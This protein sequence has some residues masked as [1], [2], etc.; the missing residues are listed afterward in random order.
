M[1]P[2]MD[3]VFWDMVLKM[4]IGIV[5]FGGIVAVAD[6]IERRHWKGLMI[7]GR[8]RDPMDSD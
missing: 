7:S 3:P 6:Y 4:F 5:L 8:T 2:M 1:A